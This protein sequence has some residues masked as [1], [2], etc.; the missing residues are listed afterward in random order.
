MRNNRN[1]T[2]NRHTAINAL[3][4]AL[5]KP[6]KPVAS[7]ELVVSPGKIKTF[8]EAA[9]DL[10]KQDSVPKISG[11]WLVADS[12]NKWGDE[13]VQDRVKAL[14]EMGFKSCFVKGNRIGVAL[15]DLAA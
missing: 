13:G 10:R 3:L 9:G 5:V 4:S 15:K 14:K 6:S 7:V 1:I 8:I 2:S 11:K 12:P